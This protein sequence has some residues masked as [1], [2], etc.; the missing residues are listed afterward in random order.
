MSRSLA[1]TP[2]THR[3]AAGL[4]GTPENGERPG[5]TPHPAATSGALG[6]QAKGSRLLN[7]RPFRILNGLR[8]I[9]TPAASH[10]MQTGSPKFCNVRARSRRR[11]FHPTRD[12]FACCT[13]FGTDDGPRCAGQHGRG[14]RCPPPPPGPSCCDTPPPHGRPAPATWS[15]FRLRGAVGRPPGSFLMSQ[16]TL[17]GATLGPPRPRAAD[18]AAR[19]LLSALC[20]VLQDLFK[21][22]LPT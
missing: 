5:P 7:E 8:T 9:S 20:T 19:D 13:C 18:H 3:T 6:Y 4:G 22:F 10:R 16:E 21:C 17:H 2:A 1:A 12:G 15:P 14:A 11:T